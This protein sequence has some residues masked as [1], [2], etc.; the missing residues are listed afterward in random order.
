MG[1]VQ[2][3]LQYYNNR[4][5]PWDDC[6]SS[7]DLS[8]YVP[9]HP[10]LAC[11]GVS[12]YAL[13]GCFA[14]MTALAAQTHFLQY[15]IQSSSLALLYYDYILTFPSEIRYIWRIPTTWPWQGS[16]RNSVST[17]LYFFC[18]YS[19]L[20]NVLYFLAISGT[21]GGGGACD[22]TY[23]VIGVVSVLGR[24]AVISTFLLRTW[25]VCARNIAVLL[26]LGT[27]ALAIFILDCI[28]V[29]GLRC[30]G[31]SPIQIANTLL[32]IFVCI[33]EGL[34]TLL[35]LAQTAQAAL[36]RNRK[37]GQM[38]EALLAE[39]SVLYFALISGFTVGATVL[40]FKAPGGFFQ[41]L[42]N[43]FTLPLSGLLTARFLLLLRAQR[44]YK[45]S[46]RLGHEEQGEGGA[47]ISVREEAS[48]RVGRVRGGPRKPGVAAWE[49]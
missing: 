13:V 3:R 31:S 7:K 21:L 42:L 34:A 23:K 28:H 43:A 39:Q 6:P 20:A 33:F 11:V 41:R 44:P 45:P 36:M 35:T 12:N 16:L 47:S 32:S 15:A 9:R 30:H 24:A 14:A 25:V 46:A 5:R 4:I 37:P 1:V 17:A 19:L 48:E 40:N 38:L 2:T 27:L 8:T 18:R 29:P 22:A 26:I 10:L 49:W